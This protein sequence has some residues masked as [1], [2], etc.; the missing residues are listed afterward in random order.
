MNRKKC[1]N[2]VARRNISG[3]DIIIRTNGKS[4]VG[5]SLTNKNIEARGVDI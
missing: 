4:Q 2:S 5:N 3:I 1:N